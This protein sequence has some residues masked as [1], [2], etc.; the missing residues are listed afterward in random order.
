MRVFRTAGHLPGQVG[1]GAF[2]VSKSQEPIVV[3]YINDQE[4]HHHKPSFK[5]EY[6]EFPDRYKIE[7]DE[8]YLW[9]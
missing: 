9:D 8:R 7:Y 3:G 6:L 2:S 4:K 1:Y 5:E